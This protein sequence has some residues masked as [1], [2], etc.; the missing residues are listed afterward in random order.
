MSR[1][2]AEPVES[3]REPPALTPEEREKQL[4][5]LAVNLAEKKLRDGTA[6]NQIIVHYLKL[7]STREALEKEIL[8][9]QVSLVAAKTESYQSIQ[10]TKELYAQA[11]DAIKLY[12]GNARSEDYDD[13]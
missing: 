9:K 5:S 6:S 1:K 7:G 12:S 10:D 3:L 11:I 13:A 2:K 4:I 8:E